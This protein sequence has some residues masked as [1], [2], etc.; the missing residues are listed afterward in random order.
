MNL[1]RKSKVADL[2]PNLLCV[3]CGGYYVDATTIIECLHSF[4]KACIVRYLE[5]NKYCPICDVQV[6]KTKPLQNIRADETLQT[7]VYKLV[8]GLYQNEMLRRREFYAQHPDTTPANNEDG[9]SASE[10]FVIFTPDESICLSL[11][12]LNSPKEI[13]KDSFS[14]RFL[15]CPAAVTVSHLQKLIRAKFGLS[16]EHRVDIIYMEDPLPESLTLMDIAYIYSWRRK[17]PFHLRYC[18]LENRIKRRKFDHNPAVENCSIDFGDLNSS[19]AHNDSFADVRVVLSAHRSEKVDNSN[20]N[21]LSEDL[22]DESKNRWK[23]VQ[24]Q[25]SENGVM[26]VTDI[27]MEHNNNNRT[28]LPEELQVSIQKAQQQMPVCC[29]TVY[30]AESKANINEEKRTNVSLKCSKEPEFDFK[31][32]VK[33]EP[34]VTSESPGDDIQEVKDTKMKFVASQINDSS[35]NTSVSDAK[36]TENS[37]NS[38]SACA[39]TSSTSYSHDMKHA[40][41]LSPHVQKDLVTVK[42]FHFEPR[43]GRKETTNGADLKL[44]NECSSISSFPFGKHVRYQV[45]IVS[46]DFKSKSAS[47]SW[48][49]SKVPGSTVITKTSASGKTTTSVNVSVDCG[50]GSSGPSIKNMALKQLAENLNSS[51]K[52][53][54]VVRA[55]N[56]PRYLGNP[57]SGV[58]PMF[59]PVTVTHTQSPKPDIDSKYVPSSLKTGSVTVTKIDPKTLSPI[60]DSCNQTPANASLLSTASSSS[61]TLPTTYTSPAPSN[62]RNCRSYPVPQNSFNSS[63]KRHNVVNQ[64]STP[65]SFNRNREDPS[66]VPCTVSDKAWQGMLGNSPPASSSSLVPNIPKNAHL[67]YVFSGSNNRMP[68]PLR[69]IGPQI[70]GPGMG[71]FHPLPPSVNMLFNPHLQHHRLQNPCSVGHPLSMSATQRAQPLSSQQKFLSEGS[72]NCS[73]TTSVSNDGSCDSHLFGIKDGC[74]QKV[75]EPNFVP[76]TNSNISPENIVCNKSIKD[77]KNNRNNIQTST[78]S[79]LVANPVFSNHKICNAAEEMACSVNHQNMCCVRTV[80][81]STI[82]SSTNSSGSS[83]N[84]PCYSNANSSSTTPGKS[85]SCL[86]KQNIK[87][88]SLSTSPLNPSSAITVTNEQYSTPTVS[89][90]SSNPVFTNSTST[91]LNIKTPG[92]NFSIAKGSLPSTVVS[93]KSSVTSNSRNSHNVISNNIRSSSASSTVTSIATSTIS[94]PSHSTT[95]STRT[96]T[97]FSTTTTPPFMVSSKSSTPSTIVNSNSCLNPALGVSTCIHSVASMIGVDSPLSNVYCVPPSSMTNSVGISTACTTTTR[98]TFHPICS[99]QALSS[100]LISQTPT[101]MPACRT[102]VRN[103]SSPGFVCSVGD[104]GGTSLPTG[105]IASTSSEGMLPYSFPCRSSFNPSTSHLQTPSISSSCIA[106]VV[107]SDSPGNVSSAQFIGK[108]NDLLSKAP[109]LNKLNPSFDGTLPNI[110]TSSSTLPSLIS[111]NRPS[112]NENRRTFSKFPFTGTSRSDN[113]ISVSSMACRNSR[114]ATTTGIAANSISSSTEIDSKAMIGGTTEVSSP[115]TSCS[116]TRSVASCFSVPTL[117]VVNPTSKSKPS[118]PSAVVVSTAASRETDVK[119]LLNVESEKSE[120][121]EYSVKSKDFCS[122]SVEQKQLDEASGDNSCV[123]SSVKVSSPSDDSNSQNNPKPNCSDKLTDI[124]VD[125]TDDQS[126]KE[127]MCI[128]NVDIKCMK[129]VSQLNTCNMSAL[130]ITSESTSLVEDSISTEMQCNNNCS[131]LKSKETKKTLPHEIKE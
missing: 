1:N 49:V 80:G 113:N 122:K 2:N 110:T 108:V 23:E 34:N 125:Q 73:L 50:K 62:V 44:S 7:I 59:Q 6:H 105:T 37:G 29:G 53:L 131:L 94:L 9:G 95:A 39:I 99:L 130:P 47:K 11:E 64:L 35:D 101:N 21:N 128:N 129:P 82:S 42:A 96:F 115:N 114:V 4:C 119:S 51:A 43:S 70:L 63:T 76:G 57:A 58:K 118:A 8:P 28:D 97:T 78:S 46:G 121:M 112:T 19:K 87:N 79:G 85:F 72:N 83:K 126:S 77:H 56:V 89:N 98:A 41:S 106:P 124:A 67:L 32:K 88:T 117:T 55:R 25:I 71:A 100:S 45:P 22:K 26:S 36:S 5:T 111:I 68:N 84:R 30:T 48:N 123:S 52:P 92:S 127:N 15:R 66:K 69:P 18:I 13:S 12:Y 54:C 14:R 3:L 91:S 90:L 16:S 120:P 104:N 20:L 102:N 86:N 40:S 107:H 10:K 33:Q 65:M 109:P 60:V 24:I 74:G 61:I 31:V 93:C 103:V 17:D 27:S 116:G 38:A 75:L 81:V